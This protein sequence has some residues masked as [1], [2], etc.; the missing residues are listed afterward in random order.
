MAFDSPQTIAEFITTISTM[1]APQRPK[2]GCFT[3]AIS[4][5]EIAA[6]L[7][8]RSSDSF[9]TTADLQTIAPVILVRLP[10]HH[11]GRFAVSVSFRP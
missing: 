9:V 4:L 2:C 3:M 10:L 1:K 6:V 5:V 7:C 11:Q 8:C